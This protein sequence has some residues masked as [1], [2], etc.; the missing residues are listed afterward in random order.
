MLKFILAIFTIYSV[1]AKIAANVGTQDVSSAIS[2]CFRGNISRVS[3]EVLSS[4]GT[5]N[6][7][8]VDSFINLRDYDNV[9]IDAIVRVNDT[10]APETVCNTLVDAL[11][12]AF[13]GTVWLNVDLNSFLQP[14]SQRIPYLEKV[15]TECKNRGIPTG[16]FSRLVAWTY[17]MGNPFAGSDK[18]RALPLWYSSTNNHAEFDDWN[19]AG[20]GGWINPT[21]KEFR[22]NSYSCGVN[23][24]GLD[25]Y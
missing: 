14:F 23:I 24:N 21:M 15:A 5:I 3:I 12:Q 18:L 2:M 22:I 16:I 4:N 19:T 8:I 20:F 6:P 13:N 17:A 10:F 1:S 9:N 11:P 7:T 25:F